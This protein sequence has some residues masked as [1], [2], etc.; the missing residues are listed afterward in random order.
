MTVDWVSILGRSRRMLKPAS[1]LDEFCDAEHD[2]HGSDRFSEDRGFWCRG[3][4]GVQG[5][6][7]FGGG[8]DGSYTIKV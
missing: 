7:S 1:R 6:L 2:V 8:V 5:L 4:F 3:C